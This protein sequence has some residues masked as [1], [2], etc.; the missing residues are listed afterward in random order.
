MI[1]QSD[2][3]KLVTLA[4]RQCGVIA[5]SLRG[6]IAN[7]GKLEAGFQSDSERLKKMRAAKTKVDE[8]IQDVLTLTAQSL[9]GDAF[10]LDAE[11][12]AGHVRTTVSARSAERVVIVDPVD[13]TLE[14]LE[15]K[16]NYSVCVGVQRERRI[17]DA[18]VYFPSRDTAYIKVRNTAYIAREFLRAGTADALPLTSQ[19]PST[20]TVYFNRRVSDDMVRE[21]TDLGYHLIDDE[22]DGLGVPDALL[23]CLEGKAV[24]YISHTRQIRDILLG[25]IIAAAPNG[26]ELDWHGRPLQ[27]PSMKRLPNAIFGIGAPPADLIEVCHR[28]IASTELRGQ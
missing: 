18:I 14:Y 23:H 4:V 19:S 11:E 27:W 20:R 16:D 5:L 13:G 15:G 9:Y 22:Q 1:E 28:H 12:S 10:T 21:L 24:C 26:H 25:T 8:I 3:T 6:Q 7:D 2:F 17:D